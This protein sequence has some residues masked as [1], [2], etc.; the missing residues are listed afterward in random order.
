M[1]NYVMC[2]QVMCF[3]CMSRVNFSVLWMPFTSDVICC[4]CLLQ[5]KLCVV[6]NSHK[7]MHVMW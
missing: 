2:S 7:Q 5:A 1:P 4:G 3:Q 6:A